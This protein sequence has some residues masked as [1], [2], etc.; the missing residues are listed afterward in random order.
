M[1][2]NYWYTAAILPNGELVTER[3]YSRPE[4][5]YEAMEHLQAT[6]SHNGATF[7]VMPKVALDVFLTATVA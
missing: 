1:K 2:S 7:V 4:I 6:Q 3:G 5:A